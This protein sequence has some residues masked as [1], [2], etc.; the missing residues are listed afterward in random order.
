[1]IKRSRTI[2]FEEW[3]SIIMLNNTLYESGLKGVCQ[4]GGLI[5]VRF[6]GAK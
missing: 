4:N 1:M 5:K 2:I 3:K 6:R